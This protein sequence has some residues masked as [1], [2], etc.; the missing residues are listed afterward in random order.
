MNNTR[1]N[2]QHRIVFALSLVASF[3]LGCTTARKN[4][5]SDPQ[6]FLTSYPS[7]YYW[8][9]TKNHDR[10]SLHDDD[11]TIQSAL[12][13]IEF[14]TASKYSI[15]KEDNIDE[16][17]RLDYYVPYDDVAYLTIWAIGRA[18]ITL[19]HDLLAGTDYYYFRIDKDAAEHVIA[20]AEEKL[21][22]LDIV[23]ESSD[24]RAKNLL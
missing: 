12:L 9:H 18:Q 16:S 1:Q 20:L 14:I 5:Y 4:S 2:K 21:S 17:P 19:G 24:S 11:S 10:R 3:L 8:Y 23:E 15:P 22:V 13:E 6:V 7:S